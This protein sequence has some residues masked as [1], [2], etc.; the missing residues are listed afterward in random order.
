MAARGIDHQDIARVVQLEPPNDA[1]TYTHRS[2][3][4]GRAGRKG[5]SSI[6]VQPAG[7]ARLSGLLKRAGVKRNGGGR[8]ENDAKSASVRHRWE[9]GRS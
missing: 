8:G 7:M 1:D 6:M 2:G 5:K 9:P 4:T 3:R